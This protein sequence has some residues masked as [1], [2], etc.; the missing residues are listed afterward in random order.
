MSKESWGLVLLEMPTLA[1]DVKAEAP[2]QNPCALRIMSHGISEVSP[3][4]SGG[5]QFQQAV[6]KPTSLLLLSRLCGMLLVKFKRAA[7]LA[8]AGCRGS[9]AG[10][11]TR[12]EYIL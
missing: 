1:M 9:Q 4:S 10:K 2:S 8:K 11:V 6:V 7:L 5:M 3:H 12:N